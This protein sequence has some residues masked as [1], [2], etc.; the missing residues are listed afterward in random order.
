M[1]IIAIGRNY[2]AHINELNNE[3]PSEPVFFMK[4]DTALMRNNQDFYFPDFTKEIHYETEIVLKINK[5][6][7]FIN[8]KFAENYFD[9]ITVGLDLTARDIQNELKKKGLP[10]ELSKSFDNSAP[11]GNFINKADIKDLSNINFNLKVNDTIVQ[12]G[13]TKNMIYSFADII[14]YISKFITLKK[15][16]LIFTGTPAGV[17]KINIGD[18]LQASIEDNCLLNIEIK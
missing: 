10:W 3:I 7:K 1:K 16:D 6:G 14:C 11:I 13:N 2:L 12:N 4:P 15:G 17:G 5:E 8:P 18:K 9:E